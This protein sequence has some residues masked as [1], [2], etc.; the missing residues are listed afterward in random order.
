MVSFDRGLGVVHIQTCESWVAFFL[1]P[2]RGYL[3]ELSPICSGEG[4]HVEDGRKPGDVNAGRGG[5]V[6][7]VRSW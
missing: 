7:K 6:V 3:D 2:A 5:V 4:V 1:G